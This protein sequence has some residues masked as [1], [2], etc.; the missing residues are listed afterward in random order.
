LVGRARAIEL[1]DDPSGGPRIMKIEVTHFSPAG[2][3]VYR[4][5]VYIQAGTGRVVREED[6]SGKRRYTM[7]GTWPFGS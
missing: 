6:L 4:G 7:F 5:Y 1:Q 2:D 3:Q